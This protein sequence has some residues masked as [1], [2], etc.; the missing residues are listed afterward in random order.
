[1]AQDVFKI[2]KD[3]ELKAVGL[4]EKTNKM[5]E[6]YFSAFR[7]IGLPIHKEDYDN[8]YTPTGGNLQK[9]LPKSD[10]VDPKDTAPK[11]ASGSLDP[12]KVFAANIAKSQQNFL[13][14]YMLLDD[15]L[16][17]N[18]QYSVMPSS[19]KVSDS[20][21]AIVNG[22][23]GVPPDMEMND[24]MKRAYD[25]AKA[26]LMDK[27]GNATPHYEAYMQY[28]D[29]YKSK[30]KARNKAYADA[31]TDPMKLQQW[32]INGVPYQDDVEEAWD[33][34]TG[35]GFKEEIEKAINTLAA[36]GTDP[37]IVLIA[38]AK[39]KF[40]NSLLEFQGIGEVPYTLLSPSS[41]Y[42]VDND[43]GWTEYTSHDFHSESHFEASSTSYGGGGG[44]NFGLWSASASFD[45]SESQVNSNVEMKN[46]SI[47]FNYCAVDVRRPWLD[48][49]LL[50]LKNWFLVG[51][52]KKNCISTGTMSQEVPQGGI[53]PTFLPSLVTSLILVKDVYISW[54]DWK[55]QWAAHTE[56]TSASGSVGVLCFTANAHYSHA[57]QKRD[58]SCDDSGE[59]LHIP[60]IQLIGYVSAINP[61]CPQ[62]DSAAF[63]KK[64]NK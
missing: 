45:H 14:T 29:A 27:D 25:D 24:D 33:R 46:L 23:N 39:K 55:S 59:E 1:M 64:T 21:F 18:N 56:S 28:E 40:V 49:S 50:N 34:W 31:F 19:S 35:L 26:K 30:V 3:L 4:D 32:P 47:R 61:P 11:T 58:F 15:K 62:L 41:W 42:D 12:N 20:W 48:T 43:D 57:N 44:V 22:A 52:Y 5:Q 36:Q 17:M 10:P 54:D 13:N 6:G 63:M 37:A 51:D 16:K 7:S 60:G 2:L 53:E 38:R 9:D 8:P